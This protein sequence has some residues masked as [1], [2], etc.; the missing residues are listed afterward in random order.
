MLGFL[1]HKKKAIHPEKVFKGS[2]WNFL[3]FEYPYPSEHEIRSSC[4]L[5]PERINGI[6]TDTVQIC[7]WK[8]GRHGLYQ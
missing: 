6:S 3:P 7:R 4:L 1:S 8:K 5:A 2:F